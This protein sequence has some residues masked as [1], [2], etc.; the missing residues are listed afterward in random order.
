MERSF[1]EAQRL[2]RARKKVQAIM[3]FYKHLAAYVIVNL[4]LIAM[5]WFNLDPGEEF[6]TFGTFSTAF[7]WGIGLVF[8]GVGVFGT[9]IFLGR[10]WEER[11]IQQYMEQ[12][13]RKS[14]WE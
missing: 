14:K 9:N 11:K 3:G 13:E 12:E 1:E 8:H 10:N 2:E 4:F 7:F 6:F 5:K